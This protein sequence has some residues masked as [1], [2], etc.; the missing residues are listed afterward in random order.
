MW[1]KTLF[2][3]IIAMFNFGT[4]VT[5]PDEIRISKSEERKELREQDFNQAIL[6]DDFNTLKRTVE[7]DAWDYIRNTHPKMSGE[8][9]AIHHR[10]LEAK[11]IEFRK[12]VVKR[13]GFRWKKYKAWLESLDLVKDN[14]QK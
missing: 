12:D 2:Q 11:I 5:P 4:K 10:L 8:E 1:I 13:R 6:K 7:Q 14:P 9:M 3:A